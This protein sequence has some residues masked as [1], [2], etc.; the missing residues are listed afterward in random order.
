MGPIQFQIVSCICTALNHLI[1]GITFAYSAVLVPHLESSD[2][3]IPD[4]TET[5][6][7]LAASIVV[8]MVPVAGFFT[9]FIM[10]YIG[11]LNT[12]VLAA[13]PFAAGWILIA[14]STNIWM[15][16]S[17]RILHGFACALGTSPAI[18]YMTEVSRPD[19][20]G[21]LISL[22]QTIAS[23]GNI[24][25][26]TKGAFLD[27]RLCAWLYV[28]YSIVPAILVKLIPESPI[29]LVQRGHIEQAERSLRKLYKRYPQPEY[30]VTIFSYFLKLLNGF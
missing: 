23:L 2:S 8:L 29:W 18:V 13:I 21:S 19:I 14:S 27:W 15:V 16:L 10:E 17:G 20:R 4:V 12:L 30:T 9:G 11:R 6:S 3:E 1:I 25:A 7:S 5:L 28:I 26:Y 22:G 24:I